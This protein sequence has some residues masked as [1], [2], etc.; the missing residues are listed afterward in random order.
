ML[1]L[2]AGSGALGCEA[3]SRGAEGAVFVE[4]SPRGLAVL[5]ANLEA[6][7]LLHRAAIRSGD[8]VGAVRRLAGEG[9]RF[10]LA[11]LDPPYA[12]GEAQRALQALRD[13]RIL[14][15]GG[16]VVIESGRRHPVP[17]VEGYRMRDQRRYG[18]TL[19][20]RLDVEPAGGQGRE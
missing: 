3:L 6:L 4:R 11:L 2:Y 17:V 19:V 13:A 1:D 14:V 15:P 18:D 7:D 12:S 5:R 9:R 20:S 10:D 8:A 16:L